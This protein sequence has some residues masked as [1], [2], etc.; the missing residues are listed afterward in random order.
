MLIRRTCYQL[1]SRLFC[2]AV[3]FLLL[4]PQALL[5]QSDES[6]TGDS[7]ER[8]DLSGLWFIS[9][10]AGFGESFGPDEELVSK[11]GEDTV[12]GPLPLTPEARRA[13]EAFDVTQLEQPDRACLRPSVA[14]AMATPFPMEIIQGHELI[15]IK[16][17]WYDL[18]R[19]IRMGERDHPTPEEYPN[20]VVGHSIGHWDGDVLVVDTKYLTTN[21]PRGTHFHSDDVRLI[22]R[23]RLS[24]DGD[25]LYYAQEIFDPP[26]L[27]APGSMF[28]AFQRE[29]G[30]VFPYECDPGWGEAFQ[31]ALSGE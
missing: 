11:L 8:P 17:E 4:S 26:V 19:V 20:S 24:E 5:A 6:R 16:L 10:F 22:E 3:S 9:G 13:A 14:V 7:S 2:L 29:T 23:F 15:V 27:E 30:Y 31:R 21:R 12:V 18:V 25:T 1:N 28:A